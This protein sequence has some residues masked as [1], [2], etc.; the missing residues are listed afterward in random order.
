M[1]FALN[2]GQRLSFKCKWSSWFL[3]AGQSYS[4]LESTINHTTLVVI[5]KKVKAG[6]MSE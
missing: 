5:Y 1:S 4:P 2:V 6:F 3:R